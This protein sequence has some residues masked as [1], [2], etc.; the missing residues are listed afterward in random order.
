VTKESQK[1]RYAA[2]PW[3]YVLGSRKSLYICSIGG[4]KNLSQFSGVRGFDFTAGAVM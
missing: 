4:I 2:G 3:G 1:L